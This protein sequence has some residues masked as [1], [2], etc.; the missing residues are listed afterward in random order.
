MVLEEYFGLTLADI[1]TDK[2]TQLSADDVSELEKIM[3][4]LEKGEPVQYVLGFAAFCGRQFR[5]APGVL[6]PRPETE[7]LCDWVIN[8]H[9][10]PFCGLQ[11]PAP[12]RILDVGTGSGCIAITLSLNMPN[13]VVT[14]YDISADAL[15]IAR[16]NAI[17]LGAT[18][19]FQ[20]KDA[21]Q[22]TKTDET[23]DV[24]LSNPP[25]ICDN[26]RTDMMQNVLNFEPTTALFVPDNDPLLF[27]RAIAEYG[28]SAL[29]HGGELYFEINS[30]FADKVS[31]MLNAL[32]YAKIEIREDQFGK[33][34]FV[35]AIHP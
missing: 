21:L 33:Q 29:S 31:D 15:L 9:S 5:V 13:S 12:L 11:P 19:N 2:V 8:A 27:Y 7:L 23:F 28:S 17:R 18:I 34:R 30:C 3:I 14:A 1:Y 20:L 6:I 25:Y 10:C 24:I 4:R 35:K 32:D 16:D 26:E 22:L